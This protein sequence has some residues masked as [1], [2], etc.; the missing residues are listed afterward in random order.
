M[1]ALAGTSCTKESPSPPASPA[2]STNVLFLGHKGS[3]NNAYNENLLENTIPSLLNALSSLDGVEIDVQMSKDGT[4]W[5]WHDDDLY[6]SCDG[7]NPSF[8]ITRTDA[9]IAAYRICHGSKQDRI[10]SLSEWLDFWKSPQGGFAMSL[11]VKSYFPSDTFQLVGGKDAYMKAMAQGLA[12]LIG[13]NAPLNA[14]LLIEVD[15]RP[16]ITTFKQFSNYPATFCLLNEESFETRVQW[17][18]EKGYDG[19]SI[20][21]TNPT[22]SASGIAQA[23]AD[24]LFV[25]LYTPYYASELKAAFALNPNAIQTD[26][27]DAKAVLNVY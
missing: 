27:V 15:Y 21:Y 23:R 2:V 12:Q 20:N 13:T 1:L 5:I 11:D 10:Y 6:R 3:G 7:E 8:F 19:I 26:N 14:K 18:K 4:L 17:A 22:V 16:F 9:E 24:G 25:Q